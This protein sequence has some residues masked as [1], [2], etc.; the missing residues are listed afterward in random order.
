[1]PLYLR[2]PIAMLFCL[3]S[4]IMNSYIIPVIDGFEWFIPALF[5]KI[6]YGHLVQEE[7]Y[8]PC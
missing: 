3:I 5:I 2:R 1:M 8:R 6:I 7:P 4:L